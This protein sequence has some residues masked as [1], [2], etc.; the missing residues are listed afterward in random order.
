M[1]PDRSLLILREELLK[2]P[3]KISARLAAE[4][5]PAMVAAIFK[6]AVAQAYRKTMIRYRNER[7][8][9]R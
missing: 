7:K 3:G 9:A 8:N 4:T 5:N 1:T 6:Q 2:I